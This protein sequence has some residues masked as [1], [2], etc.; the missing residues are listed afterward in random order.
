MRK[1]ALTLSL[2]AALSM[3]AAPALAG[4]YGK[5]HGRHGNG[6][7][8][9]HAGHGKGHGGHGYEAKDDNDEIYYL[10]GGLVG[11]LVL[12]T[13]LS[14]ASYGPPQPVYV[15]APRCVQDTVYRRLPDGRLQSGQRTLCY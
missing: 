7:G 1:T 8:Y 10:V 5:G 13:L 3:A 2:I 4:G 12:G 6:Y 14:Q 9:G 11:G 15:A